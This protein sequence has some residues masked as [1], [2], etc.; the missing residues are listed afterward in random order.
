M[1][2]Q[3]RS[4]TFHWEGNSDTFDKVLIHEKTHL[5]KTKENTL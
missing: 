4:C 1:K 3:C 5:K 2:Y